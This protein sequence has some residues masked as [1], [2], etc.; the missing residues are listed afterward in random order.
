MNT[1]LR[2]DLTEIE[3]TKKFME[4]GI[5]VSDTVTD[6]YKYDVVAD[7]GGNLYRVQIKT[8]YEKKS[9]E[10]SIQAYLKNHS[11]NN[12]GKKKERTY[13]EDDVDLFA[14]YY[15]KNENVYIVKYEEKAKDRFYMTLKAPEEMHNKGIAKQANFAEE[16]KLEN[17]LSEL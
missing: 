16:Y 5:K 15:P 7:I 14:I 9:S 4:K 8:A 6:N 3:V 2:G 12:Q 17:R 13:S 10:N 1:Q 11:Y